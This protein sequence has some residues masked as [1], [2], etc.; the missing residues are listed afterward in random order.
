MRSG[1]GEGALAFFLFFL[2][3]MVRLRSIALVERFAM[4]SDASAD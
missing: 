3:G 2:G 4:R 1:G